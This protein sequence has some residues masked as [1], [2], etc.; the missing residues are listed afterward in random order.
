[1][2]TTE[3][4]VYLT[5]CD[6]GDRA[7]DLPTVGPYDEVIVRGARVVGER[8]HLD[9]IIAAH[10][11]NGRW[12]GAEAPLTR[13]YGV[14]A[15]DATRRNIR[16]AAG[17][18][19]VVLRFFDDAAA[20]SEAPPMHGPYVTIVVG[21]HEIRADE[22]VLAVR[23]S[24]MAPWLL[25]DR[26]GAALQGVAKQAI[27]VSASATPSPRKRPETV[28]AT[29]P[30]PGPAPSEEPAPAVWVDRVRAPSEIYISRPDKS[31]R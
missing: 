27:A 15:A 25:T 14:D 6:E 21:P 22:N 31:G 12:L 1:M 30:M 23:V 17:D 3:R 29:P 11:S 4:G 8:E 5:F 26:A 7:D 13:S 19:G 9:R 20:A 18:D 10:A 16:V 2:G 24:P 28:V